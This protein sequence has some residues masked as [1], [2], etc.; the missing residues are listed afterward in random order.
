VDH[1]GRERRASLA[2]RWPVL[3]AAI[4]SQAPNTHITQKRVFACMRIG[5]L[6]PCLARCFA[7][8]A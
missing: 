2:L 1:M 6:E 4:D 7:V 8:V 5:C 3:L